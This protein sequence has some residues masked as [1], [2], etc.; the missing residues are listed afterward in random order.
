M[1]E[2]GAKRTIAAL[3]HFVRC[4]TTSGHSQRSTVRLPRTERRRARRGAETLDE[5]T[6]E[7]IHAGR[8]V[9]EVDVRGQRD[10]RGVEARESSRR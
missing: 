8:A 5:R 1:S 6:P 2:S 10:A 3:Q 4:W 7:L 9:I